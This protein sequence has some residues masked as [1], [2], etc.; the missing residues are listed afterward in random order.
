MSAHQALPSL[1]FSR[2]EHWRGS[3]ALLQGIFPTQGS[4][5]HLLCLLYWLVGSFP[6]KYKWNEIT[7]TGPHGPDNHFSHIPTDGGQC[8]PTPRTSYAST[9]HM[10]PA[11]HMPLQL[12]PQTL[13]SF[14]VTVFFPLRASP[15]WLEEETDYSNTQT[16]MQGYK[17]E[18][19]GNMTIPKEQN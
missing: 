2:Q 1:G 15:I 13:L 19:Q 18:D 14:T 8:N 7:A 10:Q 11:S 12:K 9:S 4:N 16:P 3:H 5:L 6:N 17:M